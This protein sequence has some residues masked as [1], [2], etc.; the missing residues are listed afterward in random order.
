MAFQKEVKEI[1]EISNIL[2]VD[3]LKM[4]SEA[5]S[6]HPSSCLSCAD[7]LAALFFH[8]MRFDPLNAENPNNDEFIL[9]KGHASAIYYSALFR[10]GC[11]KDALLSYRKISS[12]L[13]GHPIPFDGWI[14]A[15]TGSLGQGLS[16]GLG[17]A[18]AAKL[19]NRGYRTF[20]LLGDS[21]IA[22]GEIYEALQLASYYNLNNLCAIVDVN[23]LGQRGGT[24][25]GWNTAKYAK[26]FES[27][28]WDVKI[29]NGHNIAQIISALKHSKRAKKPFVIFAKTIK[30]KGVSFI[31]NKGGWHGRVLNKN[32]LEM[33][34]DEIPLSDFPK[35]EIKKPT[36]K[37]QNEKSKTIKIPSLTNYAQSISLATREA[38]G[39][40]ITN[41]AKNNK[42]VIAVDAEVSNS[43]F[44]EKAKFAVPKQ[45]IE[46]FIAE[47]NMISLSLGLS[48]KGFNV[49]ASSFAS[50][51]SRAHDQLRMSALSNASITVCGSHA[52]VSIGQDGASQMGLED[53]GMFRDLPNSIIFYPS[54]AI[55]TEKLTYL[56]ASIKKPSI[57]YIR[58]TR[59][60]TPII[61][62]PKEKFPLA[63]FKIVNQ[64]KN[65]KVV[66][67]GA[68]ITLHESIK[69]HEILKNKNIE[70]AV[71]DLY[72]IKPLN[73]RKLIKF[74]KKHG[75]R[76]VISEDH[77]TEGGIGEMFYGD[78]EKSGIKVINLSI[79]E[80]P[81][82][83]KSE[84]LLRKYG[85]DSSSIARSALK[86]I[87]L[88]R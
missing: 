4:T 51:L 7:I 1:R 57:K 75:N 50:F 56:A 80:I 43:T 52:G 8:E 10:A 77:Y 53:I 82:S 14:K 13:E 69:A 79:R 37:G 55:S 5:G 27:F 58:T 48:L 20:V 41:L 29:V 86:L 46:S 36:L 9:S 32:E 24:M 68:G 67:L 66:L 88:K 49:F 26:R 12:R 64:S 35:I 81:H 65:D 19:N 16:V 15:A 3:T 47:Q 2:K 6:G 87:S 59:P 74:I 83:G 38:Y 11:I 22:E 84:E 25:V 44:A 21:E 30:G 78:L 70:S 40:A 61:Y 62:S 28:G 31:E 33:A 60:K 39:N 73:P 63:G 34:L 18:L 72:C 45:F 85:I 17:M 23:R 76:V 54:D 71:I 42:K